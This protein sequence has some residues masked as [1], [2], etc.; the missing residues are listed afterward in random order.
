MYTT[1]NITVCVFCNDVL[2]VVSEFEISINTLHNKKWIMRIFNS[3]WI[4]Q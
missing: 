1:D 2:S 3:A 4:K